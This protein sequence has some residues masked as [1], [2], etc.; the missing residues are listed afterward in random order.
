MTKEMNTAS[1]KQPLNSGASTVDALARRRLLLNGLG[2][3]SVVLAA[4]AVPMHS[5]AY[6][7]TIK[8]ITDG[9]NGHVIWASVSGF[10]SAVMPSRADGAQIASGYNRAHYADKANWFGWGGTGG[11]SDVDKP[12]NSIF[13][14]S[15]LTTVCFRVVNGNRFVGSTE[16]TW[17]VAYQNARKLSTFPYTPGE[18]V[19]LYNR[20]ISNPTFAQNCEDF[21]KGYM[22]SLA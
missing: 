9:K 5:L 13:T 17:V 15:T 12:F 3:G 4:A 8:T 7:S 21:F 2:K 16:L 18:V 10:Q 22:E 19:S 1:P 14:S 6:D 11:T 20:A